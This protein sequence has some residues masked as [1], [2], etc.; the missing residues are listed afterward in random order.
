MENRGKIDK[1]FESVNGNELLAWMKAYAHVD[2]KFALALLDKFWKP[3]A[4]DVKAIVEKCFTHPS[5]FKDRKYNW[6]E[7]EED[8][9]NL[10]PILEKA[11][12]NDDIVWGAYLAGYI[13]TFSCKAYQEDYYSSYEEGRI[14][15]MEC[16]RKA[17]EIVKAILID[18][19]TL[20]EC[21]RIGILTEIIEGCESVK[22]SPIFSVERFLEEAYLV[23]MPMKSYISYINKLLR[24]KRDFNRDFHVKNKAKCLLK[25]GCW[26]K[27]KEFLNKEVK[28]EKVRIFYVELLIAH[29]EYRKALEFTDIDNNYSLRTEDW[30]ERQIR[31]LNLIGD[32][33]LTI[34]FCLRKLMTSYL[35][36]V[37]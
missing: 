19:D 13:I 34:E 6:V 24:R 3:D 31:I 26:D 20:D 4:E 9:T 8:L 21:S 14:Q 10:M 32:S 12:G 35:T 16:V 33:Q 29:G 17:V 28:D 36:I 30:I 15:M 22:D 18:D 1:I 37:R 5:F 11:V 27:T 23:T 25:N 2:D 7:V